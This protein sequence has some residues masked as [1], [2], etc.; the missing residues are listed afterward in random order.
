[1]EHMGRERPKRPMRPA[2]LMWALESHGARG[3]PREAMRPIGTSVGPW[4]PWDTR[5]LMRPMAFPAA[6]S[7]RSTQGPIAEGLAVVDSSQW[8]SMGPMGSTTKNHAHAMD[9][10]HKRIKALIDH[11]SVT[12]TRKKS[13][14]DY[15]RTCV[16]VLVY[17]RKIWAATTTQRRSAPE[18]ADPASKVNRF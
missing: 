7:Q 6:H 4:G 1:M 14:R 11:Q 12:A 10:I 15:V 13:M 2:G 9:T 18:G 8:R 16:D 3:A 5:V 17:G